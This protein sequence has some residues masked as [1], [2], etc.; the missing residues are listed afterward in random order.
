MKLDSIYLFINDC[1]ETIF[2]DAK[3]DIKK[4]FLN[5]I[6]KNENNAEAYLQ[7]FSSI[8]SDLRQDLS[9]FFDSDPAA[10]S[11]D[12][13]KLCYPGF[14]AISYYRIAHPLYKL[15]YKLEAR[16]ITEQAHKITGIDIHPGATI[17]SPFFIDH[18]TGV[19]IGETS[20]IGKR[21]KIYQGVTLG[22]LSLAKGHDLKN[23][24]RH[25]AIGDDVT[26]Y[27]GASI[28]GDITVGDDVTLGS[29]VFI[30]E[31]I[32][33]HMRVSM[34]K[35]DIFMRRNDMTSIGNTPLK[36]L[37][38]IKKAYRLYANIYAKLES[39]NPAGSVKDRVAYAMIKD[40]EERG[41][42]KSGGTLI[43][44]TSGNTGIA[45]A[46]FA[47]LYGYKAIITMPENMSKER[48]E[49]LKCYG[50]E[51]ILT[52]KGEGMKG[53]I[54]KAEE[55][56][57]EIPNSLILGQFTN[58]AN[59]QIHYET[60]GPEIYS[61]RK[62]KIDFF[63]SGVGT[64]G[65]ISGTGKY[66]KE[67]DKNIKVIAVEPFDSPLLTK[68]VAGP[69]KIQGIGAN[70]VPDTL[71]KSIYDEVMDIT[72]DEAFEY[73]KKAL[74]IEGVSLGISSG[75]AL[76]AAIKIASKEENKDKNIVIIAPDSME[77]YKS[78]L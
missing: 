30:T 20:I 4:S 28:L 12:E 65:T 51:V 19:V 47:K 73:T 18:G 74:E 26:I 41:L 32:P 16:Y 57:K 46:Y 50:A 62:G 5:N 56:N 21:V 40:A 31:D 34:T 22:A 76:A 13:I 42:L 43:E 3:C 78:V 1:L 61:Q 27:S 58:K 17:A 53:A 8:E 77:K 11:L 52:P 69:H 6:D 10:D 23:E 67:K 72:N 15:G 33:S 9:F 63:V 49:L 68:G 38:T 25:P 14:M 48:V 37:R 71:D 2:E 59:P 75:A 55:L 7:T 66:L 39:F 35:P 29:N 24:K 64:G 54:K 45:I 60:T 36:E 70:F 44:P